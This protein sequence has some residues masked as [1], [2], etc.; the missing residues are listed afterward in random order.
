M[1]AADINR[2]SAPGP[3]GRGNQESVNLNTSSMSSE[4][5]ADLNDGV[6]LGFEEAGWTNMLWEDFW[7]FASGQPLTWDGE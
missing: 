7:T 6:D 5:T 4:P 2:S 1:N 3:I